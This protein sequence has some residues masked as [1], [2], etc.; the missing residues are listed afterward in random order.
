MKK[1]TLQKIIILISISVILI[2]IGITIP[3]LK[4]TL[5]ENRAGKIKDENVSSSPYIEEIDTNVCKDKSCDIESDKYTKIKFKTKIAEVDNEIDEINKK[6]EK[7]RQSD[8]KIK[9]KNN[10]KYNYGRL[11]VSDNYI[12]E[13]DELI[14]VSVFK[15]TL[16]L[17]KGTSYLQDP[18]VIIY[19]KSTK[20]KLSNTDVLQMNN[21]TLESF[22][23]LITKNITKL[24]NLGEKTFTPVEEDYKKAYIYYNNDGKLE[25]IHFLKETNSFYT[26]I[27]DDGSEDIE[28]NN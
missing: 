12:Y 6:T 14:S 20:K 8:K 23:E 9:C 3:F 13:N 21:L 17:C 11:T 28:E 22:N 10:K 25:I 4:K 27:L 15:R 1:N 18:T 24:A 2:V 19:S 16:N 5:Q 7:Y 26:F